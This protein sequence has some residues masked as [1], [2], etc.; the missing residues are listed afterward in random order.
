MRYANFT[1]TVNKIVNFLNT[2]AFSIHVIRMATAKSL[3]LCI[4]IV[5]SQFVFIQRYSKGTDFGVNIKILEKFPRAQF[6]CETGIYILCL[7]LS[8]P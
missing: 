6:R 7:A 5:Q 1:T 8:I 3:V 2:Q 4:F